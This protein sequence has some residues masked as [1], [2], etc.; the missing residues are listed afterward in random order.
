VTCN[1]THIQFTDDIDRVVTGHVVAV[2]RRV[3]TSVNESSCSQQTHI[4][5]CSRSPVTVQSL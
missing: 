5:S 1:I 2:I 4:N 3:T